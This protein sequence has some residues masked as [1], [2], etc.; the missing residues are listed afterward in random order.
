MVTHNRAIFEKY[1]GRVF[2]CEGE[3]CHEVI[4]QGI[5]VTL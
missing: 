1:P 5:D 4:D 2:S 3:R